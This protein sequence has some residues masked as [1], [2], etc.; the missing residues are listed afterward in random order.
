MFK[1]TYVDDNNLTSHGVQCTYHRGKKIAM[2]IF[3]LANG[4]SGHCLCSRTLCL[5]F[6]V[7]VSVC[8]CV[9]VSVCLCVWMLNCGY[10][11]GHCTRFL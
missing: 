8:P 4:S 6:C 7:C 3:S 9:R 10:R 2:L 11:D 1:I 5:C